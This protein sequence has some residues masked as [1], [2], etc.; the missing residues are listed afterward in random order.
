MG[1]PWAWKT[2]AKLICLGSGLSHNCNSVKFTLPSKK[3]QKLE[4][5]VQFWG[6]SRNF[7][8][9]REHNLL[10]ETLSGGRGSHLLLENAPTRNVCRG[11][12]SQPTFQN[13]QFS[14]NISHLTDMWYKGKLWDYVW[15]FEEV[16]VSLD[17]S[18]PG[19]QWRRAWACLSP[20]SPSSSS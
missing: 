16:F 13:S 2:L 11:K 19:K 15:N 20:S 1:F 4:N 12:T 8:A 9:N 10:S 5:V 3:I 6:K 17:L 14:T 18:G 7:R